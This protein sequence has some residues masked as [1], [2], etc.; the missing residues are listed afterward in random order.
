V[1]PERPWWASEDAPGSH[2]ADDPVVAFRAARRGDRDGD[3][4]AADAAADEVGDDGAQDDD[5]VARADEHVAAACGVCPWCAT[6]RVVA[7]HHPELLGHVREAGR[8]L[9]LAARAALDAAVAVQVGRQAAPGGHDEDRAAN[10]A[11]GAD[12]ATASHAPEHHA[13]EHHASEDH[14]PEDHAPADGRLHRIALDAD[15]R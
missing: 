6:V 1:S 11:D 4:T 9:S 2:R 13:P 7:Q 8:H 10:G 14:A 12:G 5:P 3:T 15:T